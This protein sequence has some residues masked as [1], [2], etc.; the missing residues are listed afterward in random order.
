ML[1]NGDVASRHY[2]ALGRGEPETRRAGIAS[3]TI[4]RSA[5]T[6]SPG[7][8]FAPTFLSGCSQWLRADLG[9]TSSAGAVSTWAD[10]GGKGNDVAQAGAN[11]PTV[12][13]SDAAYANQA[14][15]SFAR[16]SSQYLKTTTYVLAQPLTIVVVGENDDTSAN[17]AGFIDSTAGALALY[18]TVT[19]GYAAMSSAS[20]V[21]S[22]TTV[23]RKS[24]IAAAYNGASSS[25]YVNNSA[26][27][28][29]SGSSGTNGISTYTV[30]GAGV[31]ANPITGKIAEVIVYSR[32]V[33][34]AER[35]MLFLY[36][37]QRYGIATS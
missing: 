29:V 3:A 24:I 32:I 36:L 28:V 8:T 9:I 10:Q 18:S 25:L 7:P 31:N 34:A 37:G 35:T 17:L 5:Q 22:T 30:G 14:T 6:V 19:N 23:T 12:N 20:A 4:P 21:T 16:A 2:R 26:V 33:S 27:A 11:K 1:V 13:T 15:I